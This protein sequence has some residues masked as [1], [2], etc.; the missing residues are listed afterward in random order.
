MGY[1]FG[2]TTKVISLT[3]G[4]TILDVRDLY[5]RWKD[6]SQTAGSGYLQAM[7][8]VG[9][10]PV[11]ASQGIYVTSYFFLE[12]GWKI[13]PQEANHKLT[14]L[15]GVLVDAAG[16]GPFISTIG[17]YNVLVQYSQPVKSET[18]SIS[19]SS[20]P[21]PAQIA[22]AVRDENMSTHTAADSTGELIQKI[23]KKVDDNQAL[24][25][26]K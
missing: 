1:S 17:T 25:I 18:V 3:S 13:K 19:G 23:E 16:G 9:G 10:D 21:T 5:S 4:T 8:V 22:T 7:S 24:I 12:N 14:V 26:S 15:N 20:G 11:D 2:G 6:W